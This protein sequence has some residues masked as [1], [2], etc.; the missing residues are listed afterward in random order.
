MMGVEQPE[1][2][3]KLADQIEQEGDK[4]EQRSAELGDEISDVRDDWQRKRA[5]EGVP[6]APPPQGQGSDE[7]DDPEDPD[8]REDADDHADSEEPK[9]SDD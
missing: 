4:M 9:G 5:D 3:D 7:S 1:E 6:G 8:D 2:H